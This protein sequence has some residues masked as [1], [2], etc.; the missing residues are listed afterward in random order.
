LSSRSLAGPIER[1]EKFVQLAVVERREL[2][3]G[4]GP[5]HH[6]TPDGVRDL[7]GEETRTRPS[8]GSPRRPPMPSGG[9]MMPWPIPVQ[10]GDN[11]DLILSGDS[12]P[13][14]FLT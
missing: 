13:A 12:R 4:G 10:S 1:L 3:E 8:R 7:L 9:F 6:T 11:F 14:R 2:A 5:L